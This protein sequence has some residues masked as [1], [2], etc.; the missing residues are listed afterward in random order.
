MSSMRLPGK[1]L[2]NIAGKPM[3]ERVRDQVM[4]AH[5]VKKV[6]I[7]TSNNASDDPIG[8]FCFLRNISCFRGALNDVA[9]RFL[10][11]IERECAE[12]FI[13]ISGD[14]PL[15]DPSLIDIAIA[16]Y[17]CGPYDL[18]T[19]VLDR[20]FPKGQSVELVRT[21]SFKKMY[22]DLIDMDD[23][24]HVTKAFYRNKSNF[25]IKNFTAEPPAGDVQLSV[26]TEE[27][28]KKVTAIINSCELQSNGWR[29]FV[30][31]IPGVT[32]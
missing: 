12:E 9:G 7:A 16:E 24:E 21:S 5:G 8:Q 23:R 10:S 1:V 13:R 2:M 32:T 11:V 18:V 3:L 27:D 25:R 31:L 14:S 15:I 6:V 17:G 28:L 19:N 30:R 22:A 26:D 29:D 20:T 4:Q